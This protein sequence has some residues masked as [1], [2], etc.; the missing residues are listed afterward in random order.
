MSP[1]ARRLLRPLR[2]NAPAALALAIAVALAGAALLVTEARRP[3]THRET[4]EESRWS[5]EAAFSYVVPITR[6]ASAWPG[7]ETLPA[8]E[9]VYYRTITDQIPLEFRWRADDA[10]LVRGAAEG[11]MVARVV[12]L[13]PD[14][15]EFWRIE[16]TLAQARTETPH[17]DLV[18]AGALPLDA[19]V[20][21]STRISQQLPPGEARIRWSVEAVVAYAHERADGPAAGKS[22]FTLP[23]EAADPRFDLPGPEALEWSRPHA[24]YTTRATERPAGWGAALADVR[25]IAL[26]GGGLALVAATLWAAR[27]RLGHAPAEAAWREEH[28]EHRDWIT[29]ASH[30]VDPTGFPRPCVDVASLQDLVEA[31]ADARTRVLFDPGRRLYYAVTPQV[32]YRYARHAAP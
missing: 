29:P 6:N 21:E 27:E 26:L 28:E 2:E 25:A 30:P 13:A 18:L 1:L 23:I 31:A 16:R 22:N 14:G 5:E 24:T 32:T 8:G 15:R 10:E 4:V 19:L 20:A 11:S 3:V 9:P 12:A 7:E 17:E